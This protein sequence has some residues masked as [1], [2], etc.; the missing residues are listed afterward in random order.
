MKPIGMSDHWTTGLGHGEEMDG[1]SHM[2]GAQGY[3]Y[4][5]VVYGYE[6]V[7]KYKGIL[8]QRKKN[9][10]SFGN[11]GFNHE[12]KILALLWHLPMMDP[13]IYTTDKEDL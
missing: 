8:G 3:L 1:T 12:E 4:Y 13:S 2:E 5:G 6:E 10:L 11:S 9:N 7:A